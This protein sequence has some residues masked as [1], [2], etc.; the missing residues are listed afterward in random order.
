MRTDPNQKR[1]EAILRNNDDPVEISLFSPIGEWFHHNLDVLTGFCPDF[2]K[3]TVLHIER[4][5]PPAW[6]QTAEHYGK[7]WFTC[8]AKHAHVFVKKY[9][10][11]FEYTQ[12]LTEDAMRDMC[13]FVGQS[14]KGLK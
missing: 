12:P 7:V 4:N 3:E 13:K 9:M 11:V 6:E 14:D 10:E 8:K 2:D 1:L 5:L